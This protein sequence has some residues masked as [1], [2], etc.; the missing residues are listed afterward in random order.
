MDLN[1]MR[2]V[3]LIFLLIA[4][5]GFQDCKG[6]KSRQPSTGRNAA[7]KTKVNDLEVAFELEQQVIKAAED[8]SARATF[9][10]RSSKDIRLNTLFL[11]FAPILLKVRRADGTPV[12]PTS[13]PFP[14]EDDGT[15][16][17]VILAP[18]KSASFA[19]RGV[20]LFGTSLEDGKY[21]VRFRYENTVSEFN[22]WTG[23][24]E[25]GWV[26]FEVDHDY[27]PKKQ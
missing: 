20:D 8:F 11:G 13:P 27:K 14:P 24:I 22:D 12:N 5:L 3:F 9:T 10:N 6:E 19:Y 21:E 2:V 25:T 16:G 15:E 18:E 17:R 23:L 4:G 7:V 1:F 26:S